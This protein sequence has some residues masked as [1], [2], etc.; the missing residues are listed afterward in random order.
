MLLSKG[1]FNIISILKESTLI[2]NNKQIHQIS[3]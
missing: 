2:N 1:N 3:F